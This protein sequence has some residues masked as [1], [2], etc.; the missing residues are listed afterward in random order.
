MLLLQV[1]GS[2]GP[3]YGYAIAQRIQ[4]LSRAVVQVPQGSLYPALHRLE[5]RRLIAAE[6]KDSDTGR[7]A[8][9]Y[10]LTAK[11]RARLDEATASW[12]RLSDAVRMILSVARERQ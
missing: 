7:P 3:V 2:I 6:W 9:F 1:I 11:G 10:R 8:K 12:A 4:H 5:R